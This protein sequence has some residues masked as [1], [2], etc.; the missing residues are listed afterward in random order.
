MNKRLT[1][2][3]ALLALLSDGKAQHMRTCIAVG[4]YRYGGRIHELRQEGH[5][6]RTIRIADDEFAYQLIPHDRQMALI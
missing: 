6:I 5:D 3:Q 1:H 2:K 4:G